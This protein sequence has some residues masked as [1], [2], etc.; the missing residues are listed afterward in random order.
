MIKERAF[1]SISVNETLG[2]ITKRSENESKL[3]DEINYYK[4]VPE[5]LK[6]FFPRMVSFC[7]KEGAVQLCLEYYGYD[8]LSDLWT[9]DS[10]DLSEWSYILHKINHIFNMFQEYKLGSA[11]DSRSFYTINLRNRIESAYKFKHLESI[12]KRDFIFING[13]QYL[14]WNKLRERVYGRIHKITNNVKETMIHGD[15]CF[16]N[17]LIG[18]LNL[19]F[20]DVRGSF[21][22]HGIYG[23]PRYDVAKIFHSIHGGYDFILKGLYNLE[24]DEDLFKLNVDLPDNHQEVVKEFKQIFKNYDQSEIIFIEGLLFVTMCPLHYEDKDRQIALLLTGIKILNEVLYENM[25]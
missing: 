11:G 15:P 19:K 23:D 25:H 16:S 18:K 10:L 1:N 14:G 12:L 8:T 5:N 24:Y 9:S 20:V 2:T 21:G 3:L 6:T 17:I 4:M 22:R 13:Q 7:E